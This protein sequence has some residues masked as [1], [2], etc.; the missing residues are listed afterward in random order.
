MTGVDPNGNFHRWI[1]KDPIKHVDD[2][3]YKD[4]KGE[5]VEQRKELFDKNK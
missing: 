3:R 2:G 1:T 4:R 5:F